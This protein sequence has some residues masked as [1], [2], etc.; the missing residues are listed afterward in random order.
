MCADETVV[1]DRLG[2]ENKRLKKYLK[3]DVDWRG[4]IRQHDRKRVL[5]LKGIDEAVD[6]REEN[7]DKT[8]VVDNIVRSH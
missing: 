1:T 8:F 3:T 6:P 4:N 2:I 7:C 5:V